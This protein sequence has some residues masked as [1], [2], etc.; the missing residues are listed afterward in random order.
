MKVINI[1]LKILLIVLIFSPILG[2]LGIFPAP[3]RDMYNTDVAYNFIAMLMSTG[4][5]MWIMAAVFAV[6]IVLIFMNRMALVALLLLPITVNI[7]AFH[8]F[9][10]GGLFAP[11][12]ILA[13]VLLIIN[14]IFLWQ[15]RQV[16][17]VLLNKN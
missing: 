17:K 13:D 8:T 6:C 7:I 3:T 2:A 1:I 9:L 5:I 11:D 12:A 16:Y 10:D 15:Q 4:Y 14:V